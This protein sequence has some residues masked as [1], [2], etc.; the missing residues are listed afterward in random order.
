MPLVVFE[1]TL[2]EISCTVLDD[3]FA[4]GQTVFVELALVFVFLADVSE[5]YSV[6]TVISNLFLTPKF[7]L[8]LVRLTC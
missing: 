8:P 3:A 1:L 4:T 6:N 2:V 5:A 7:H